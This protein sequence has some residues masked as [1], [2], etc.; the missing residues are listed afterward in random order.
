M[1]EEQL[2]LPTSSSSEAPSPSTTAAA[3]AAGSPQTEAASAAPAAPAAASRPDWL[4]EAFWDAETNAPLTAKF[5]Q[6][7]ELQ[8]FKAEQDSKRL[9]LPQS[10][11]DYKIELPGDLVIPEG[12]EFE[13][14]PADPRLATLK[15]IALEEGLGQQ[16]FSKILGAYAAHEVQQQQLLNQARDAEAKKLG[17][18]GPAR[19]DAITRGL[20]AHL[21]DLAKPL[22]SMMFTADYV[23]SLEQMLGKLSSQGVKPL[24]ANGRA[25]EEEGRIPGYE[26]MTFMQR[27][28]AQD[29]ARQAGAR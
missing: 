8:A 19:I 3:P 20:T 10:A 16:G 24:N 29:A 2:S 1:P 14:D 13:I 28:A 4:P 25:G 6:F 21:G 5:E 22:L 7:A 23:R 12:V 27:R 26:N 15:N 11:D 18:T 9:T 17:A